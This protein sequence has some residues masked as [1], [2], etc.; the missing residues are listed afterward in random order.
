MW[1]S[2]RLLDAIRL[3]VWPRKTLVLQPSGKLGGTPF[4]R[5]AADALLWPANVESRIGRSVVGNI[6]PVALAAVAEICARRTNRPSP[7]GSASETDRQSKAA[8][9]LADW[10][11][12]YASHQAK[13][14]PSEKQISYLF[15]SGGHRARAIGTMLRSI[16]KT[17]LAHIVDVGTGVGL[18]PWLLCTES[19][20]SRSVEL[21][22]PGKNRRA[23]LDRL[24]SHCAPTQNYTITHARAE[25]VA[26]SQP[27]DLVMFCQ[28]LFH[29]DQAERRTVLDRAWQALK[30]G[31]VLL[32]NEMPKEAGLYDPT[33]DLLLRRDEIVALMP[34]R[35]QLFLSRTGWRTPHD[36]STGS[37]RALGATGLF[38]SLRD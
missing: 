33:H 24:W 31:G 23:A 35:S 14:F 25:T 1:S 8:A 38:V 11:L 13:G 19:E 18:I 17:T 15:T 27:T 7:E 12:A 16:G 34:G 3:G 37:A 28:C 21:H 29:I 10:L 5:A 20:E 36:P 4:V 32:V 30:P 26:F 9:H 22:E 2:R 6:H